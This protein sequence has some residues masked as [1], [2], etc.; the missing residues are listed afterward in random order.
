MRKLVD[1]RPGERRAA[2][3][4]VLTLLGITAGH[5]LLET[6]RDALFLS[7]LPATRLPWVYLAIAA[8]GLVLSR[9]KRSDKRHGVTVPLL[10]A[11]AITLGFWALR[12]VTGTWFLYALY[13]WTGVFASWVVVEFW[14]M[15]G[16]SYTVVQAK[17]LYGFIGA[18]SVLGAVLGALVARGLAATVPAPHLLLGACG[19]FVVTAAGP[20]LL[21]QPTTPSAA[22]RSASSASLVR[23]AALVG[24]DPYAKR[25][26]AL[27][28]LATIALTTV[29]Y[30]FK[31][32]VARRYAPS[33]LAA[34]FATVSV[35]LNAG[36]LVVQLAGVNF[37]LRTFGVHRALWV[38]PMLMVLGSGGVVLG[39]QLAAALVLKG[40][41]GM[42]RH[43]LHRTSTELLYV[44]M[45]D[46][47]RTRG[48]PFIDLVGQRGGQALASLA[49]L[50]MVSLGAGERVLAIVVAALAGLWILVAWG[51]RTHYLDVFRRT[52][53]E[54]HVGYD[55]ALP[56]LDLGALEALFAAL[57]SQKDAEVIGA[58][59]LLAAH[60]RGRLI[61]ALALYHPSKAV[62]L[63]TL[64]L[65][66]RQGRTDFLP[67]T[68]RLMASDDPDIRAA[69]LRARTAVA[70]EVGSLREHLADERLEVRATAL[71]GLLAQGDD[72]DAER[73]LA[74]IER[75]AS[76]G[77]RLALARAI[78][79]QPS[80]RFETVLLALAE[81]AEP[82][83][84]AEVATAMGRMESEC[85]V[86]LLIGMLTGRE[87]GVAAREALVAIGEPALA[88]L[89]RMLGDNE[90][91]RE[92]RW[93]VPRA[94]GAFPASLAAPILTRHLDSAA[95][96]VIRFRV[97]RALSRLRANNA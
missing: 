74:E 16:A 22:K 46:A 73:A 17:R 90:A 93:N 69:A 71:V 61:P 81:S 51:I 92:V 65:L 59:D 72:P 45:P 63:R 28:L 48:K 30:I 37:V 36:A 23:D 56:A 52:L 39:G 60:E 24:R 35:V 41:D 44:P 70:P 2:V 94:I 9:G 29:D 1:L 67:I 85:F 21:L 47:T 64:D 66:A 25:I 42:L 4:A 7:R 32:S 86:P 58:L 31:A 62:V 78:G 89:D 97:L 49:I 77:V 34:F 54:G 3:G 96:G 75:A 40:A 88:E 83:V 12:G 76:P 5:T 68:D 18:G 38:L 13:V 50:A 6:A 91:R 82:D 84:L 57:N 14:L 55:G 20:T 53:H 15:L 87:Q 26:L 95:N 33:E 10:A 8:L 80:K 79:E 19:I 27:V 43:S 11:T